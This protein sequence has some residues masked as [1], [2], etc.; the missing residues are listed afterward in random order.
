MANSIAI[1]R[2]T[3]PAV[4]LRLLLR[5]N[6]TLFFPEQPFR[7][8]AVLPSDETQRSRWKVLWTL[9]QVCIERSAEVAA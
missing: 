3:A 8:T 2:V 1:L 7:A 9:P 6:Y 4:L 5:R